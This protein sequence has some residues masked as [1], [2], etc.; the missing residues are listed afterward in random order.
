M[1]NPQIKLLML[2]VVQ[3]QDREQSA[4]QRYQ[5]DEHARG[6]WADAIDGVVIKVDDL[7]LREKLGEDA[8]LCFEQCYFGTEVLED[9]R[10][11]HADGAGADDDGLLGFLFDEDGGLDV[12]EVPALS[13]P[14]GLDRA[15]FPMK[16]PGDRRRTQPVEI[17]RC[18]AAAVQPPAGYH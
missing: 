16:Q 15:I 5:V 1:E 14:H 10:H 17:R 2:A 6:H 3:E 18:A 8:F 7:A 9:L 4:E 11:L 13:R 12:G